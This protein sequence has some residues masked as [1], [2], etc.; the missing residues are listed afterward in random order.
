MAKIAQD[1]EKLVLLT[2]KLIRI[3]SVNPPGNEGPIA[4]LVAAELR[5]LG[6]KVQLVA[7]EPGR[8]NVIAVLKGLKSEIPS[9]CAFA[10]MDEVP[11]GDLN[12]WKK[13]PFSGAIVN[14]RIYGRGASDHKFPISG[15]VLAV[16]S[17]LD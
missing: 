10:H 1:Q 12:A 13:D 2:Q 16:K 5:A 6:F 7:T 17:I 14:G 3:P 9:L 11:P 4:E 8:T 15:L